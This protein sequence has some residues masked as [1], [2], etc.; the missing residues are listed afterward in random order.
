M[1]WYTRI[2]VTHLE[3]LRENLFENSTRILEDN[4]KRDLWKISCAYVNRTEKISE[5]VLVFKR[6]EWIMK[7]ICC[8]YDT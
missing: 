7:L 4:I 3:F 5:Q 6:E 8:I 1:V 2:E